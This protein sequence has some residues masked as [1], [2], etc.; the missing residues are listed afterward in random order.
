MRNFNAFKLLSMGD[1]AITVQFSGHID[2][3]THLKVKQ[4]CLYLDRYPIKGMVEYIPT[5]HSVTIFY[6][7]IELGDFGK[8]KLPLG[9]IQRILK[10]ILKNLFDG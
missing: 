2:F 10:D 5:Y 3:A 4:L 9:V 6:D 1:N 7:L 8:E